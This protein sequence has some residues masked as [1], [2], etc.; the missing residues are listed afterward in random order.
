MFQDLT[1]LVVPPGAPPLPGE[2]SSQLSFEETLQK[3][4]TVG[5]TDESLV[6]PVP[7]PSKSP[8]KIP[9]SSASGHSTADMP[10]LPGA[11]KAGVDG[12]SAYQKQIDFVANRY[13]EFKKAAMAAKKENN[14]DRSNK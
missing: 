3:A 10:Q 4:T 6:S 8:P 7:S 13:N 9:K 1:G 5:N 14:K 2:S 12:Q 11:V